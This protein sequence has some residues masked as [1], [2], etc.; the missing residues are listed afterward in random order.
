MRPNSLTR[1]LSGIWAGSFILASMAGAAGAQDRGSG[2]GAG[3]G[4]THLKAVL[5]LYT[6]QGCNSC[7]PADALLQTYI[8]RDDVMALTLPVDYWDYIG[9]KDTFASPKFSARQRAY[10]K[11]RGDG[12]VYTP[13]VVING[14]S[15][16]V[17]SSQRDIDR[18]IADTG[19]Q[20]AKVRVPVTLR[21]EGA[22]LVVETGEVTGEAAQKDATIWLAAI[23][24]EGEV[25]I[26]AGENRGRTL[27]YYNIVRELVPV[28]MW[29][30]KAARFEVSREALKVPGAERCAVLVQSGSAG[31]ILGAAMLASF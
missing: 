7:P 20:V 1:L 24:P 8:Q 9:W 23:Q 16:V 2:S 21:L 5:E 14:L 28:G 3:T 27:K 31:P 4:P 22:R 26:R 25:A 15:H 19:G 18:A 17:G 29:S 13:Q 6:S 12:R 30:G 11:V 10:A